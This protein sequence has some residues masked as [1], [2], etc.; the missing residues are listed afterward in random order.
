MP[1]SRYKATLCSTAV[2][3]NSRQSRRDQDKF[4]QL[5]AGIYPEI[6]LPSGQGNK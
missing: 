3:K 2:Q 6:A 1:G 4:D 5:P